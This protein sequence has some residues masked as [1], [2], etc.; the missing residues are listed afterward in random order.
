MFPMIAYSN[1]QAKNIEYGKASSPYRI[2]GV[3]GHHSLSSKTIESRP[4]GRFLL[5][6]REGP[7]DV[8][9]AIEH[10][11]EFLHK[12][13]PMLCV[14]P[15]GDHHLLGSGGAR[16][17]RKLKRYSIQKWLSCELLVCVIE[18]KVNTK[19][20]CVKHRLGKHKTERNG[21][22]TALQKLGSRNVRN[23]ATTD[24]DISSRRPCLRITNVLQKT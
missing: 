9:A 2:P 23:T 12:L 15:N 17:C 7:S 21:L 19:Y 6:L 4:S 14:N 11:R 3:L 5:L 16:H 8:D 1:E 10:S 13:L 18:G 20:I 24:K 22:Q